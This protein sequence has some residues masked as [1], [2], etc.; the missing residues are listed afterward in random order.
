MKP[1]RGTIFYRIV[2]S[3]APKQEDRYKDLNLR[4]LTLDTMLKLEERLG[5]PVQF[6]AT[7][8]DDHAPHRH[9]HTLV[10]V[11]GKRLTREDFQ[12]L[13]LEATE[14]ALSQRRLLDRIRGRRLQR[15]RSRTNRRIHPYTPSRQKPPATGSASIPELYLF[16]VRLFIKPCLP[17]RRAT[18]VPPAA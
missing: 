2:L 7:L 1:R 17:H 3:P 10:L 8:H 12:A 13:R 5:K 6:V 16:P 18:A 9:V 11:Q 14:R 15:T 4:D